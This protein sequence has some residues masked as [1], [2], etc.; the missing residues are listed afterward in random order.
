MVNGRFFSKSRRAVAGRVLLSRATLATLFI[1]VVASCDWYGTR[2]FSADAITAYVVDADTGERIA[3]ANVLASWVMK[4]GL[5]NNTTSYA[6]VM[7]AV[8]D[9][10]GKFTFPAWGPKDVSGR[11]QIT[12]LAPLITIFKSGYK[13]GGGANRFDKPAPFH[14]RSDW[15]GKTF[16]LEKFV[17][18]P[19]QYANYLS[20]YL[21][22]EIHS[23]LLNG[24][25]ASYF[26]RFLLAIDRE[27]HESAIHRKNSPL[28]DLQ[29]L[30]NS[31]ARI[32]GDI[33]E[34]VRRRGS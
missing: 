24:C 3:G 2:S 1:M 12:D 10:S 32:C 8:S 13:L 28:E 6:M 22:G 17:G 4:S 34:D 30:S 14:M 25:N 20:A 15:D 31:Y 7:E 33:A 27:S 9:A 29:R 16:K 26:P 19:D 11:G 23:L 5:E 21:M 18:A